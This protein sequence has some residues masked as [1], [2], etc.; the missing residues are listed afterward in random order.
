MW[1]KKF[2]VQLYYSG[3]FAS[4][5]HFI[6]CISVPVKTSHKDILQGFI[7]FHLPEAYHNLLSLTFFFAEHYSVTPDF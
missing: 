2:R 5:S 7:V 4:F 3:S 1:F 6:P